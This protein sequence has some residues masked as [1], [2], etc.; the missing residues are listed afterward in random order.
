MS[1]TF[2][3]SD[4]SNPKVKAFIAYVKSLEFVSIK[5]DIDFPTMTEK[6]VIDQAILAE[7]EIKEGKTIFHDE[8]YKDF[9]K[10]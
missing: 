2:H 6:E 1:Y 9:K 5:K 10:W 3:I 7:K 8:V 4:A